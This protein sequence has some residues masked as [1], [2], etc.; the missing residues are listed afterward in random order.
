VSVCRVAQLASALGF[1]LIAS[2]FG[3]GE[4]SPQTIDSQTNWLIECQSDSECGAYACR[5]GV[6][7]RACDTDDAC[8]ALP[9]AACLA[10]S[11]PGSVALCGGTRPASALCLPRCEAGSCP[12]GQM[13]VASVCTPIPAPDAEVAVD[14]TARREALIGFGATVAFAEA[15]ITT[16]PRKTELDAAAFSGL[17]LDVLRLRNRYGHTGDDDLRSA[18]ALLDA[19]TQSLG[20]EPTLLL[21]SWSPPAELKAGGAVECHGN[22]DTCTL[23]KNPAG[24]FDYA[25]FASFWRDSLE[26][27]AAAGVVPDYIG[28][29]NNPNWVPAAQEIGQACKFLPNEGS[30]TVLIDGS[31]VVVDYPGYAEALAATL[32]ALERLPALPSV[33]APET[34]DFS[35]VAEYA[36][37]LEPSQIDALAHHL[38]GSRPESVDT[39]AL[40]ALGELAR[41]YAVPLLQ[42]EMQ[43]DGFGTA[44]LIHYTA[45]VQGGSAYLQTTLT[46]SMSGPTA[47]L[48]ALIG[49]DATDFR[50]QDP[51]FAMRHY[52]FHTDPGW[53]RVDA[54]SSSPEIMS[55]AWLSPA[56]DALTVVLLNAGAVVQRVRLARAASWTNSQVTRTVFAGS[57]RA[58]ALG[59][60]PA[61]GVL[62][63]PDRAIVTVTFSR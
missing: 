50:L 55:S 63:I 32:D 54:T 16:H 1:L 27:Y 40:A 3:C 61:E 12:S 25:G 13:C 21:T 5:C 8:G 53:V 58:A 22:P 51:Y 14:T 36:A 38:Y 33:L 31:Q 19:A 15:E 17:G 62:T 2:A 57:E 6:C 20:R 60:L 41:G 52:A 4:S 24:D 56:E 34:S 39:T 37:A 29:Q 47:N 49:I 28:I 43:A 48:Q 44:L 10:A 9:G 42:T 18:R 23:V 7:T 11:D 35:S 30:A 59:V 45:V 46:S 26:A